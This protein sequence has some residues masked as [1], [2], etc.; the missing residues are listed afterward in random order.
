MNMPAVRTPSANRRWPMT[1]AAWRSLVDELGQLRSEIALSAA[2]VTPDDGVIHL[3]AFNAAR[4]LEVLTTVLDAAETV[5]DPG[6][7]VIGRRFTL[8]EEDGESVTYALV[9][10]G[11][12]DPDR[13]WI[14]ADAPLGSAVLGCVPGDRVHVAAPAGSRVVTVMAVE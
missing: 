7:A 11:D 1:R 6:R 10:P 2:S 8:A 13:G 5:D 12:G 4:R 3:P 9:F 14:S